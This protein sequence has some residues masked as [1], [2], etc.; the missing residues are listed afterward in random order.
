MLNIPEGAGDIFLISIEVIV[1]STEAPIGI[2]AGA[3][4]SRG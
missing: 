2:V 1:A 4:V 3:L